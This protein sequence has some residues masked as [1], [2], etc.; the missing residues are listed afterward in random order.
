MNVHEVFDKW[1]HEETTMEGRVSI[2]TAF[3][4]G[5]SKGFQKM[6]EDS[7]VR[8]KLIFEALRPLVP[9][10]D[11]IVVDALVKRN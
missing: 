6:V 8:E 5:W 2:R 4:D 9:D 1:W 11:R 7:L 10:L 3:I